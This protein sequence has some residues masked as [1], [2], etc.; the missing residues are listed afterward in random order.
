MLRGLFGTATFAATVSS[1]SSSSGGPGAVNP[2]V[3]VDPSPSPV[4]KPEDDQLALL[5][6]KAEELLA[7]S[8]TTEHLRDHLPFNPMCP[9]CTQA[10][11]KRKQHR[12]SKVPREPASQFADIMLADTIVVGQERAAFDGSTCSVS[13]EDSAT[14]VRAE[15]PALR[16]SGDCT[17]TAIRDF[18]GP[19]IAAH[20]Q[21]WADNGLEF[22]SACSRLGIVHKTTTPHNPQSHGLQ[23]RG[24]QTDIQ[25]A[26]TIL[27]CA[28]FPPE[29]WSIALSYAAIARSIP[30]AYKTLHGVDFPGHVIPFGSRVTVVPSPGNGVHKFAP[31]GEDCLFVGWHLNPG[32]KF[33]DY[34]V[35][36]LKSFIEGTPRVFR[37]RDLA[38]PQMPWVF[39]ARELREKALVQHFANM[40]LKPNVEILPSFPEESEDELETQ[41]PMIHP[42][43]SSSSDARPRSAEIPKGPVGRPATQ[44]PPEY[45]VSEEMRRKWTNFSSKK[46]KEIAD[47]YRAQQEAAD[48]RID[49]VNQLAKSLAALFMPVI[50]SAV[51]TSSSA[52]VLD[53]PSPRP[54]LQ[55]PGPHREFHAEPPVFSCVTRVLRRNDKEWHCEAAT[56]AL[57]KECLQLMNGVV[58]DLEPVEF[59]D[60]F[61]QFPEALIAD[62]MIILGIKFA[63]MDPSLWKFK[64]RSVMRGDK[65]KDLDGQSVFFSDTATTP[66]N[67]ETFR[68]VAVFGEIEGEAASTADAL[69]AFTQIILQ[70]SDGPPTFLRLVDPF[71]V[72][73]LPIIKKFKNPYFRQRRVLYGD[74]RASL[75]W[76]RFLATSLRQCGWTPLPIG[77]TFGKVY[78]GDKPVVLPE[79]FDLDKT[80]EIVQEIPKSKLR[81]LVFSSYVDDMA[82]GGRGQK[83]EWK[84]LSKYV[85]FEEPT[86]FSRI[87]GTMFE[88]LSHPSDAD[89]VL[90][91]MSMTRYAAD[92]CEKYAATPGSLK[93]R[94]CEVPLVEPSVEILQSSAMQ[95][96]GIMAPHA[97]S[98]LMTLLY[99]AR[100]VRMDLS[101]AI[102]YLARDVTRWSKVHDALLH[103]VFCY[104]Y[105]HSE[106]VLQFEIS[107]SDKDTIC[108]VPYADSDFAGD[109]ATCRSTSGN[110][111]LLQGSKTKASIHWSSK[112]QSSVSHSSTE[113][114]CVSAEKVMREVAIPWQGFWSF[115]LGRHILAR[116][117]EDNQAAIKVLMNGYSLALRHLTKTHR[118]NISWLAE[119]F[120]QCDR[121]VIDNVPT[122]LQFADG[123]TKPLC[124]VKLAKAREQWG[125]IDVN[126]SVK[127]AF[128][129]EKPANAGKKA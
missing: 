94:P 51:A 80:I 39:P 9:F 32:Y 29:F 72:K 88:T 102:G 65:V 101:F 71:W 111:C 21:I 120:A 58:F 128:V 77:Q 54:L 107:K 43:S 4:P 127:P 122:E 15:Y 114:E 27:L 124:R 108:L 115:A 82:M 69:Q 76:E 112:R 26:R 45:G 13:I 78:D 85:E 109:P 37:T 83:H 47:A 53:I 12:R 59:D 31:A 28:G 93:L 62:V 126:D 84:L 50:P 18:V 57:D 24:E 11:Q 92:A 125:L 44:R 96:P 89:L 97:A 91:R 64:A 103:K 121:Y 3:P 34:K 2:A 5:P 41:D 90:I 113:A 8:L 17:E 20:Q 25:V 35:M 46:K 75:L 49:A 98:L 110:L 55:D 19:R 68:S 105:S 116:L 16:K 66:S 74:Q 73:H 14:G 100:M 40:Q 95:E 38:L 10:K 36:T 70:P 60:I 61:A 117:Q 123:L 67:M 119:R 104:L 56:A 63:E 118:V 106:L 79:P 86:A 52:D 6:S 87:L 1:S 30:T 129:A 33:A 23:E 22:E 42:A 48:Q 99:L 81:I 7:Q